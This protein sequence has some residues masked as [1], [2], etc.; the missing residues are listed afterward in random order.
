MD[1]KYSLRSLKR[2]RYFHGKVL[3][4]E[5]FTVE[6]EYQLEKFRRHN[7]YL[8]GYGVV[9]GLEVSIS[10]SSSDGFKVVISPGYAIDALGREIVIP[11]LY[12]EALVC[13]DKATHV[14]LHYRERETDLVG[15][16][17]EAGDDA[18]LFESSRIEESFEIRFETNY[19]CSEDGIQLARLKR[20]KARW[21]I[22]KK[23]QRPRIKD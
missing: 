12:E 16:V 22:D 23:F 9:T 8:H 18:G 2:I 11:A 1:E 3:S 17:G 6:Q 4:A 19:P 15:V 5:D 21:K 7:R 14:C 20:K 13:T 10:S